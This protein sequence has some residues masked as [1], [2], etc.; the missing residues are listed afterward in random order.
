MRPTIETLGRI[1][2]DQTLVET[3]NPSAYAPHIGKIELTGLTVDTHDPEAKSRAPMRIGLG[4]LHVS[5]EAAEAIRWKVALSFF[6]LSAA[7]G[8]SRLK[9]LREIG[10]D[11]LE[12]GAQMTIEYRPAANE[13][14]ITD[15]RLAETGSGE[16]S[17]TATFANVTEAIFT[18]S[19]KIAALAAL[20]V[21][22][23]K[24]EL[25]LTNSGLI[26]K[27][28][29]WRAKNTKKAPAQA[30]ADMVADVTRALKGL[31]ETPSAK[32]FVKALTDFVAKPSE[33]LTI[34]LTADPG[35]SAIDAASVKPATDL[36]KKVKVE[37]IRR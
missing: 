7:S 32:A 13:I 19:P 28:V 3:I 14:A 24:G 34:R 12:G 1:A 4:L 6:S 33:P 16:A 22:F 29:A 9:M 26:D 36:W 25:L 20:P 35:V 17:A 21:A 27:L 18:S 5:R 10:Y 31:G 15:L 2:A 37:A 8:D 30:R 11:E 23:K